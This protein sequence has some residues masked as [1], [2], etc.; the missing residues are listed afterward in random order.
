MIIAVFLLLRIEPAIAELIKAVDKLTLI[1]LA[2]Q[3]DELQEAEKLKQK[4]ETKYFN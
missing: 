3:N 1:K 2:E 4:L